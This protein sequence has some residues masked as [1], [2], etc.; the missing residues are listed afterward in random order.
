MYTCHPDI[1]LAMFVA[2]YFCNSPACSVGQEY[3]RASIAHPPRI[4]KTSD[5]AELR[6]FVNE[7]RKIIASFRSQPWPMEMKMDAVKLVHF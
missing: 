7:Q 1:K 4:S 2:M 6:K 3:T 5:A